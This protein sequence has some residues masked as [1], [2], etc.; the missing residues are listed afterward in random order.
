MS[1]NTEHAIPVSR[2]SL[3]TAVNESRNVNEQHIDAIKKYRYQ[4]STSP[5]TKPWDPNMVP[6]MYPELLP[7]GLGGPG[8]ESRRVPISAEN[9]YRS[10]L[11]RVIGKG[12]F[13]KHPVYL[14]E[15]ADTFNKSEGIR[16]TC[17]SLQYSHDDEA[18]HQITPEQ[19]R[20]NILIRPLRTF[21]PYYPTFTIRRN[22]STIT[23]PFV[24]LL[25][26][27]N[28]SFAYPYVT[29]PYIVATDGS[30]R[31]SSGA[32]PQCC[33]SGSGTSTNAWP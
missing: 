29:F 33:A 10:S 20:A 9:W 2:A 22:I 21:H 1:T 19:V 5:N 13:A 27:P 3:V 26:P 17:M 12:Q 30:V 25:L 15:R 32:V 31:E 28:L 8:V 6:L 16:S 23:V 18:I 14:M 11:T 4:T 24:A 7:Y